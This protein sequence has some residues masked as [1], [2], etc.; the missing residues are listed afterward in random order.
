[1]SLTLINNDNQQLAKLLLI[2][3]S[4]LHGITV[5]GMKTLILFSCCITKGIYDS[6]S[7]CYIEHQA[8]KLGFKLNIINITSLVSCTYEL[9]LD[10]GL[11][12][13]SYQYGFMLLRAS[14]MLLI[15][16]LYIP[17]EVTYSKRLVILQDL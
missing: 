2:C 11:N 9:L 8:Y 12:S 3:L 1:M 17:Y 16:Q 7:A 13:S 4:P 6:I 14:L 15:T 10:S 5:V